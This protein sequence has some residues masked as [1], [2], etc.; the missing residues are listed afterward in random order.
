VDNFVENPVGVA[1][2]VAKNQ[3]FDTL[4]SFAAGKNRMKSKYLDHAAVISRGMF[5]MFL[6]FS[7]LLMS[8][9]RLQRLGAGWAHA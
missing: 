6:D 8:A 5:C 4:M 3:G 1:P 7:E 9:V 2:E